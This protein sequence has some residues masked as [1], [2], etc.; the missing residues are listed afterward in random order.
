[1][2]LANVLSSWGLM[3]LSSCLKMKSLIASIVCWN[4]EDEGLTYPGGESEWEKVSRPMLIDLHPLLLLCKSLSEAISSSGS[5][6][7]HRN[8]TPGHY[9]LLPVTL[10]SVMIHNNNIW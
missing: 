1:M 5:H 9:N 10:Y 8:P 3:R 2:E 6:A 4:E 7:V